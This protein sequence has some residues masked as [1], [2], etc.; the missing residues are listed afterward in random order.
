MVVPNLP[1]GVAAAVGVFTLAFFAVAVIKAKAAGEAVAAVDAK[2]K[3]KTFF[4]KSL[5][6]DA[7]TV[8]AGAKSE[9]VKA[10]A[11]KVYEAVRYADPMSSDALAGIEGQLTVKFNEFA[12]AVDADSP[13]D[14]KNFAEEFLILMDNRNAKCKLLK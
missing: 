3:A 4:V 2:V 9:E 11:K 12:G 6:V 14:A 10:E 1:N 13:E 8:L 5:T 7:Q